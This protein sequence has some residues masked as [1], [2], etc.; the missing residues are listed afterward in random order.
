MFF[1]NTLLDTQNEDVGLQLLRIE[2]IAR[3]GLALRGMKTYTTWSSLGLS[4]NP[5]ALELFNAMPKYSMFTINIERTNTNLGLKPFDTPSSIYAPGILV[6]TKADRRLELLAH[7]EHYSC[8]RTLYSNGVND[9]GWGRLQA[10]WSSIP[11]PEDLTSLDQIKCDGVFFIPHT[12]SGNIQDHP[13][14]GDQ[15]LERTSNHFGGTQHYWMIKG[16]AATNVLYYKSPLAT[17]WKAL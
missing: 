11:V 14:G 15:I 6:C 10:N 8:T 16:A 17:T 13:Y 2:A 9:T 4:D 7:T 12:I 1:N 5:T 3:Q